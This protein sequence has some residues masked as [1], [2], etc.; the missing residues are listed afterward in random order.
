M[1]AWERGG[2]GGSRLPS[3]GS[4]PVH[5]THDTWQKRIL[6][7]VPAPGMKLGVPLL[8]SQLR[9][10]GSPASYTHSKIW[11]QGRSISTLEKRCL[12]QQA[13]QQREAQ[14]RGALRM[15]LTSALMPE[16]SEPRVP[17]P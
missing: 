3:F 5:A 8:S 9:N 1:S 15:G 6:E 13:A 16:G 17:H 11:A 14:G 2:D 4:C 7:Q 10:S 12:L